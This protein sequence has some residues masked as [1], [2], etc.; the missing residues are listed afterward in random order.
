MYCGNFRVTRD[1]TILLSQMS[2]MYLHI[3]ALFVHRT[4]GTVL[5]Y[6]VVLSIVHSG[7]GSFH[8]SWLMHT[9]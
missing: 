2:M 1:M 4:V 6:L 5:A 9:R 3:E 7:C 8:S